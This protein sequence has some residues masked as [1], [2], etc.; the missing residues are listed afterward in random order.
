MNQQPAEEPKL[1]IDED[2]KTQV[3][4]EKEELKQKLEAEAARADA[5]AGQESSEAERPANDNAG[6]RLE[7]PPP[8][9]FTLLVT[10]LA[11][12]AMA[13][14]GLMPSGADEETPDVRLDFAKHFIDMLAVLEEKTAGNLIDAEKS[15]LQ[16]ALHQLRMAFVAVSKQAASRG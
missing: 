8:A 16:E 9:S 5:P 15:Y 3:Q 7:A 2:W 10:T 14:M 4:R 11:S 6:P 1:I 13:A 12:Q